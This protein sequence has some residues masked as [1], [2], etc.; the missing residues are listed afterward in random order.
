[1]I[2][3]IV[4]LVLVPTKCWCTNDHLNINDMVLAVCQVSMTWNRPLFS[5]VKSMFVAVTKVYSVFCPKRQR[6]Y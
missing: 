1:M 3:I 5:G 6:P 2:R 4:L